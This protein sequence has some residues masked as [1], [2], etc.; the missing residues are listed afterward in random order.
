MKNRSHNQNQGSLKWETLATA[1]C[2]YA[3]CVQ[4][5]RGLRKDAESPPPFLLVFPPSPSFLLPPVLLILTTDLIHPS[6]DRV[7]R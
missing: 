4:A 1:V 5:F 6:F 2:C 3:N 7:Q